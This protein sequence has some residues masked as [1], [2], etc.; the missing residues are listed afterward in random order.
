MTEGYEPAGF[1]IGRQGARRCVVHQLL[2]AGCGG[3]AVRVEP[4]VR[5]CLG[6]VDRGARKHRLAVG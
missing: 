3:G 6:G 2:H 4:V 1:A 5:L